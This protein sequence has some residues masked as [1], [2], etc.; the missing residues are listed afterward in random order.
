MLQCE[1]IRTAGETPPNGYSS[2][3]DML[4]IKLKNDGTL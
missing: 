3:Y 1:Y 4:V 2:G